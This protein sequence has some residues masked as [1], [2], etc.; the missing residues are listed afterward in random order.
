[1]LH[2]ALS[3]S[4]SPESCFSC[5]TFLVLHVFPLQK[6]IQVFG[7]LFSVLFYL[8]RDKEASVKC[9]F[10]HLGLC[11]FC[12]GLTMTNIIIQSNQFT[13][14]YIYLT[15]LQLF[16]LLQ[17]AL[18]EQLDLH[19]LHKIFLFLG[20]V[21]VALGV[22][23]FS[24]NWKQEWPT[25][26]VLLS[27]Q[28]TAPFLQ[29]GGVGA[30]TLLTSLVLNR[31]KFFIATI[32][33]AVSAA[34]FLCPVFIQSP[35]L[36]D[37][38]NLPE[39]PK[40]IGHR[41]APMLAPENTM[42]S[43]NRSIACNM[44]GLETDVQLSKDRIPFLMHDNDTGF[45]LRTTNVKERFPNKSFNRSSDLTFEELQGLNAGEW[46]LKTDPFHSVSQLSEEEK[47]RARQQS[48]PSLLQLLDLAK[49]HNK[50]VIFD[51]YSNNQE[52]DTVDVVQTILSSGIDPSLVS[53][54]VMPYFS[55]AALEYVNYT[56]P[57]FIHIYNNIHDMF[58]KGGKHLNVKYNKLRMKTIR[59]LRENNVTVNLWVVNERWLFSLLWCAGASSV[60]TNSCDLQHVGRPDWVMAPSQYKAIWIAVD[61]VSAVIMIGVFILK[62]KNVI[63]V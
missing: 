16:A 29:F 13:P 30:L 41:G 5:N 55:F 7:C 1:F 4:F 46:F 24:L 3:I 10:F 32:F 52:N 35:C 12:V 45:L 48:I 38:L 18:G 22:T 43:F 44:A 54:T 50:S 11:S 63:K 26:S 36:I 39:K 25:I 58:N 40:L 37:P 14:L 56:A 21:F 51:L 20:V 60:T 47:E 17:V 59:D 49:K 9:F 31:S 8:L 19:W 57:G 34:I 27:L 53:L 33:L 62:R 15:L 23:G 61:I 6:Y 42:M 28:A 2:I